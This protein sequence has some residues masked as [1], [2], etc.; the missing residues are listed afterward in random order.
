MG[1][2]NERN[3]TDADVKALADEMEGR[4]VSRFYSNLGQGVWSVAWKLVVVGIIA[5][6]AYGSL[7]K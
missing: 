7:K 2:N 1:E 4:L 3:L 6:V 5:L